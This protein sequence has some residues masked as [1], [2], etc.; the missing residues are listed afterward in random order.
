MTLRKYITAVRKS[1]EDLG[2]T[3][4]LTAQ[5]AGITREY[6]HRVL[7]GHQ[8]PSLA[9]AIKLAKAVGLNLILKKR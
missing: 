4:S 3:M 7:S 9:V 6:L 1:H 5:R 8:E 2:C